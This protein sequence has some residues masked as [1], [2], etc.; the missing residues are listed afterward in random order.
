MTNLA[1][2]VLAGWIERLDAGQLIPVPKEELKPLLE[3]LPFAFPNSKGTV[4][5]GAG[6]ALPL[7]GVWQ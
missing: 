3:L 6:T 4:I 5:T 7:V 1:A 2:I